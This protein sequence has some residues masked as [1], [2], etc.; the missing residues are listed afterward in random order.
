MTV[1]KRQLSGCTAVEIVN[2][3]G[4][5]ADPWSS[6]FDVVDYLRQC[7]PIA[8]ISDEE[9]NRFRFATKSRQYDMVRCALVRAYRANMLDRAVGDVRRNREVYVYRTI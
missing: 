2:R 8:F 1:N 4:Q 6:V 7:G 9:Y 3:L 5:G